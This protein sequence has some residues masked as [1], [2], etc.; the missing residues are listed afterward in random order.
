MATTRELADTLPF[1]S[2]DDGTTEVNV[3][4]TSFAAYSLIPLD[5][6]GRKRL[7]DDLNTAGMTTSNCITATQPYVS[8]RT[9]RDIYDHHI[10]A[11]KGDNEM[12]P[13]FIIVA[14]QDDWEEKGV[15]CVYLYA[16][17]VL[18][19]WAD[20]DYEDEYTVGVLRCAVVM[21]DCI[22]CNLDIANMDFTEFK[23]GEEREWDGEDIWENKRYSKYSRKT[24]ELN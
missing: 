3:P 17:R 6:D 9:L 22:C 11:C 19:R 12:H 14:D 21:A 13:H 4:H 5:K 2:P 7:L 10:E 15:L 24:G 1:H 16:S 8:G 23:E 20:D 18:T